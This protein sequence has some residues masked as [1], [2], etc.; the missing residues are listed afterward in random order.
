MRRFLFGCLIGSLATVL[1]MTGVQLLRAPVVPETA[2]LT[3]RPSLPAD[4]LQDADRPVV[5]FWGN[6]LLFDHSWDHPSFKA[7]NCARQGLTLDAALPLMQSLPEI[8]PNAVLLAFGS[9]ELI[10][11]GPIDLHRWQADLDKMLNH[12][13]THYPDTLVILSTIP[14]VQDSAS[15]WRYG[16]RPELAGMNAILTATADTDV[17]NLAKTLER[18]GINPQHYDGVHLR[19]QSYRAWETA[20]AERITAQDQEP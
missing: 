7:V 2:A 12:L 16:T 14:T 1:S 20:L 15:G 11:P 19:E 18:A 8:A 9:V 6:S 10:R 17:I 3:C 5:L 13:Q 4:A